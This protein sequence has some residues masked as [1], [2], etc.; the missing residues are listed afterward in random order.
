MSDLPF[1]LLAAAAGAATGLVFFGGLWLTTRKVLH[2]RHPALLSLASF[3]GRSA[4]AVAVFYLVARRADWKAVIAAAAGFLA[5]R[6]LLTLQ[7][8]RQTKHREAG[9]ER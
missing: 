8:R 6:A 5:A 4:A 2:S 3:L 9:G 7:V 1:L